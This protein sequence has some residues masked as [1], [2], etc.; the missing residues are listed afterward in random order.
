[1]T[2]KETTTFQVG[3]A[4]R[5]EVS[6]SDL[7]VTVIDFTGGITTHKPVMILDR[8]LARDL[9]R[10]LSHAADIVRTKRRPQ[11][12]AGPSNKD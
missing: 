7:R 1:M 9:S 12:S 10:A 6:G 11:S 8:A 5:V 4:I 3:T 2:V